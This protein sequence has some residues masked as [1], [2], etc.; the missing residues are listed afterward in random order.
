[1]HRRDDRSPD[2]LARAGVPTWMVWL[3]RLIRSGARRNI[4]D[5]GVM[6]TA[7]DPE[8]EEIIRASDRP[9]YNTA[10]VEK[11]T[12]LRPATFRAWERRYGFPKP[13]RLSGNQRLYSDRDIAAIR[14]LVRRT[15]EG[16]AISQAIPLLQTRLRDGAVV[17]RRDG[18]PSGRP[19]MALADDLTRALLAFDSTSAALILGEAY[20]MYPIQ[21][22]CL[23]VLAPSM[24]T[25]GERWHA[26]EISVATEHFASSFVRRKLF[27]LFNVYETGRGRGLVFAC[28]APDEWH[29]VGV[30][31]VSLFLVRH[32]FRLN[33]LG[34]N[35]G[36]DGLEDMLR[37]HRP[38]LLIVSATSVETAERISELATVVSA[39]PEP[40]PALAFG[41]QA[42]ED[43][44]RRQAVAGTYLGP[45]A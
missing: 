11:Q 17:E 3:R 22:V 7:F 12:G 10:A 19:T 6:S 25:V 23:G 35:L 37:H 2:T 26:G 42:F 13:R 36:S 15:G 32:G 44:G 14:W 43:E 30:L 9:S 29:E 45:D 8:L 38:D 5:Q 31:M 33:Y 40:R 4:D 21:E 18:T 34:P 16:L 28:C 27:A 39:M 1:M 20:A 24:V 41:G